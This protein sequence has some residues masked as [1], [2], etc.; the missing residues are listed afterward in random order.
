MKAILYARKS[1]EDRK[2]QLHSIG[3]Q[4]KILRKIAK[5]QNIE[6]VEEITESTVVSEKNKMS[7]SKKVD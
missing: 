6:I 1:T 7:D 2:R 5:K 4:V 3:D